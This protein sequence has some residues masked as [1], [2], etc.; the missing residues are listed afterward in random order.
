[1]CGR[2]SVVHSDYST[3]GQVAMR[4]IANSLP[5]IELVSSELMIDVRFANRLRLNHG[6]WSEPASQH[7]Q[8]RS[9]LAIN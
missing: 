4:P 5:Y 7:R 8:R 2:P 6:W 9:T 3:D 1:M